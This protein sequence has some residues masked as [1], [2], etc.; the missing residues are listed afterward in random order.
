M[1]LKAI[2]VSN[3][4]GVISA[5]VRLDTPIHLFAGANKMGKSSLSEAVRMA[6][7]GETVRVDLKKDFPSLVADDHDSGYATVE[8]EGN[9][10]SILIPSGKHKVTAEL[11]AALPYVLDAQR[12]SKLDG[13]ARRSFLFGLTGQHIGGAEVKARMIKRGCDPVKIES[14]IP[15]LRAGFDAGLKEAQ[16]KARECKAQ[17]KTVVGG[18][19]YGS[20]KAASWRAAKPEVDVELLTKIRAA[21]VLT[22]ASI[23]VATAKIGE[24]DGQATQAR[25]QKENLEALREKGKGFARV[26]EKLNHDEAEL[27]TWTTKV[28]E[29][30]TLAG[31]KKAAK[32]KTYDCPCCE[33]VLTFADLAGD[34]L[35]KYIEPE[36]KSDPEA[37]A[38]LPEYDK[39][40]TLA[41]SA[42]KNGKRDFKEAEGA[43]AAIAEIE[44]AGLLQS[45]TAEDLAASVETL[46]KLKHEKTNHESGIRMAEESERAAAAAD[47]KTKQALHHHEAVAAWE[48]IADALAPSGIPGEILSEALGSINAR[49]AQSAV[50]SEWSEVKINPDMSI[51]A[52]GRVYSLLSKSEKFRTDAMIAEA[53][54]FLSGIKILVLD[55]VDI[56]DTQKGREDL[57]VWLDILAKNGEIETA[58]LFATWDSFTDKEGCEH[59]ILPAGYDQ[60][61]SHWMKDGIV[62]ELPQ[63]AV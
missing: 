38:K 37:A 31:S 63:G 20:V 15:M 24:L 19:T 13:D 55:E 36:H 53:I 23:A 50:D 27:T 21:L 6:L 35:I 49:L 26:Q 34:K 58:L 11:P 45:P 14:V 48:L 46:A 51:T 59:A 54:S 60:M 56:L 2:E 4:L 8:W 30:R 52:D 47:T 25:K 22:D 9:Q 12:F 32:P 3:F 33:A 57:F 62:G 1:K 17:W 41:Q 61:E 42:V 39:C 18:E 44:K 43:L 28:E 40:L 29:T 10:A 7:V 16:A 5:N